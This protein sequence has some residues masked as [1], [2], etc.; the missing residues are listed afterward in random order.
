MNWHCI[1]GVFCL[2]SIFNVPFIYIVN[3]NKWGYCLCLFLMHICRSLSVVSVV[4]VGGGGKLVEVILGNVNVTVTYLK[5]GADQVHPFIAKFHT[6]FPQISICLPL[7]IKNRTCS[8][9]FHILFKSN[10]KGWK[11]VWYSGS[12][13]TE[14]GFDKVGPTFMG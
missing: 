6:K 2:K 9:K 3:P 1:W 7:F 10:M 12:S 8:D 4:A 14:N 11:L 13:H 5:I